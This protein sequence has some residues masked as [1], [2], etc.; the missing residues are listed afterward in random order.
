MGSQAFCKGSTARAWLPP[1]LLL[2][3][4]RA[5]QLV[6]RF[7][8]QRTLKKIGTRNGRMVISR[9]G[10]RPSRLM[11]SRSLKIDRVMANLDCEHVP[12]DCDC[13]SLV[14]D[15]VCTYVA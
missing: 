5:R 6:L 10:R 11:V 7:S 1:P 13:Q 9:A 14:T 15:G 4:H 8:T 2:L 12:S 3:Q